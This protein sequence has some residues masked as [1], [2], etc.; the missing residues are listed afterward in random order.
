MEVRH[1]SNQEGTWRYDWIRDMEDPFLLEYSHG[2]LSLFPYSNQEYQPRGGTAHSR[3]GPP[4]SIEKMLHEPIW[5]DFKLG[6]LFQN[7]SNFCQA[8]T[9]L[10]SMVCFLNYFPKGQC[11]HLH[12]R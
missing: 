9:R 7:V 3:L 12:L 11:Y 10:A 2:L 6:L 4:T 1:N 5:K 8:D